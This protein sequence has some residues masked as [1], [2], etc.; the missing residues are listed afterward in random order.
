MTAVMQLLEAD[1]R[2]LWCAVRF[3]DGATQ[4]PVQDRL[5]V[6]APGVRWTRN[7][8][9]LYIA[10]TVAQPA[11]EAELAA[12][13]NAFNPVPAVAPLRLEGTVTDPTGRFLTRRFAVDLPRAD[14]PAGPTA[15]RFLPH[16]VALDLAPAAPV[17]GTWA[18]LRASVR[19]AGQ[20]APHAAL[21]VQRSGGGAP[22]GRG[23][24]DARGE[25]L[26][27]VAGIAQV[28]VGAGE[29][30]VER[31]IDAEIVVSFDAASP[32][33]ANPAVPDPDA[34]AASATAI[35]TTVPRR[36]ASGRTESLLIELP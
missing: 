9:G 13:E 25:A 36:L 4:R 26:I 34:L 35:R 32:A 20:P 8:S 12:Y 2:R 24:S 31:E 5:V 23:M 30:V 7:P 6:T 18:V 17:L 27:A 29:L 14:A 22:L 19:R 11:R 28:T 33:T 3:I 1:V 10:L 16:D 21:R 15:P